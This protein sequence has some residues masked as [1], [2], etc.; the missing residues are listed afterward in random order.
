MSQKTVISCDWC[1]RVVNGDRIYLAY[2][3][4]IRGYMVSKDEYYPFG[5]INSKGE[6]IQLDVC[7]DQCLQK[8]VGNIMD[9]GHHQKKIDIQGLSDRRTGLGGYAGL[10]GPLAPV[11]PITGE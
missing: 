11:D 6:S 2:A 4:G 9:H 5:L 7:G 3:Q 1:N 10:I 8:L